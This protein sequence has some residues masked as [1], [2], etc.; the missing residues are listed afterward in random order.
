M[1]TLTMERTFKA[2]LEKVYAHITRMEHLLNWWGPEGTT[3]DDH[4]LS[5]A[6]AGP[7]FAVMVGPTGQAAKVVGDVIRV[8]PPRSIE[9]T[10]AFEMPDG[11]A[12]ESTTIRFDLSPVDT[13]DTHLLLTQTGVNP[14]HI[15]DMRDK[16][17]NSALDRLENLVTKL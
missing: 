6:D 10:L 8:D 13:G 12:G 11:K 4:N 1:A 2:P 16:G 5:F 14:D 15:A 9:L 7:W 3:I 17:W